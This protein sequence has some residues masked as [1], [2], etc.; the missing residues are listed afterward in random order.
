MRFGLAIGSAS[1]APTLFIDGKFIGGFD[2][3]VR[4]HASE[5]RLKTGVPSRPAGRRRHRFGRIKTT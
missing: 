2:P 5:Q 3:L 1:V 4:K